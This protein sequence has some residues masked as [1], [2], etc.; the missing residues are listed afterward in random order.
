MQV[1][2]IYEPDMGSTQTLFFIYSFVQI[3]EEFHEPSTGLGTRKG[4]CNIV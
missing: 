3:T 2:I 4:I 1:G